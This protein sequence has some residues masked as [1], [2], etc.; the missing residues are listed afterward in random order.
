VNTDIYAFVALVLQASKA[1][2]ITIPGCEKYN[3]PTGNITLTGSNSPPTLVSYSPE[4]I[5]GSDDFVDGDATI[6][7]V[8]DVIVDITRDI[9]PTFGAVWSLGYSTYN[10][11]VRSVERVPPYSPKKLKIPVLVIGNTADPITP[12]VSAKK[13]ADLLGDNAFLVEQLGFGHTSLAQSSACTFGI[14]AGYFVNSTLPEGRSVQCPVD[15]P[16][17]FPPLNGTT[18]TAK[19]SNILRRWW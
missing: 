8:F 13:T 9:T 11:P 5:T 16:D 15:N 18:T 3:V 19:R 4:A 1:L 14:M 12:F 2:N 17:L 6:K 10:W 7:D